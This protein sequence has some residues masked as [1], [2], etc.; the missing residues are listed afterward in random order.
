MRLFRRVACLGN[1]RGS[2]PVISHRMN[3]LYKIGVD[4]GGSKTELILM[5]SGGEIVA[6][7]LTAGC[8][9]SQLGPE[10]AR[11]VLVAALRTLRGDKAIAATQIYAAGSPTTWKEIG[12]TIEG[13]GAVTTG[14]DS[15]PVLA[16]ATGGAPGLVL[17]SGTGSFIA[18]RGLDGRVHFF[19]GLGWKLGDPGSG[20]D[21]GRRGI[22]RG[23][24]ELQGARAPSALGAALQSHFELGDATAIVRSVYS[25]PDVTGKIASFAPVVL[26]LARENLPAAR[27]ILEVSFAD[28]LAE[29]RAVVQTLF[30]ATRVP[31]GLSGKLLNTPIS[32]QVIGALPAAQHLAVDF[33]PITA[34]PIEGVRR[35]LAKPAMFQNRA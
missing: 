26:D 33:L 23:L 19:G 1:R 4:G 11:A 16:L 17:H 3:E 20:F 9:P 35:L 18:A 32:R 21:L 28:L 6:H 34:D 25:V 29:A 13:F 10:N 14:D 15:L 8:N 22:A 2:L 7:H 30:A 12:A 27:E 24:L 31:C 5:D